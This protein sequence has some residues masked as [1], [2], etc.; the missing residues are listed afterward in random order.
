M[1]QLLHGSS[2]TRGLSWFFFLG[3]L[4]T[5][6][7]RGLSSV[8]CSIIELTPSTFAS[9]FAIVYAYIMM[10]SSSY[11]TRSIGSGDSSHCWN[12]SST[13][14]YISSLASNCPS[15]DPEG[16]LNFG[17]HSSSKESL[18][19]RPFQIW[20]SRSF[21]LFTRWSFTFAKKPL[22]STFAYATSAM[23]SF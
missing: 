6:S 19:L 3:V 7:L 14:P 20:N 13:M 12:K 22:N 11:S 10:S 5:L 1:V 4:L 9:L 2:K 16:L 18:A 15:C 8:I 23:E 17:S 21:P